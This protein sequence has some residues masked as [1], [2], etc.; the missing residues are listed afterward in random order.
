MFTYY[1]NY[2]PIIH[3]VEITVRTV[4]LMID[5]MDWRNDWHYFSEN[6]IINTPCWGSVWF[7]LLPIAVFIELLSTVRNVVEGKVCT[8]ATQGIYKD[9]LL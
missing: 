6:T 7:S 2:L 1:T 8:Y 4:R 3:L 9:K 5:L